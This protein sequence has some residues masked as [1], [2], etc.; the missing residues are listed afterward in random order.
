MPECPASCDAPVPVGQFVAAYLPRPS[1]QSARIASDE[2][3]GERRNN[4]GNGRPS[5]N[6]WVSFGPIHSFETDTRTTTVEKQISSGL[7]ESGS[8]NPKTPRPITLPPSPNPASRTIPTVPITS[9]PTVESLDDIPDARYPLRPSTSY[10]RLSRCAG[11]QVRPVEARG[12]GEDRVLARSWARSL[13]IVDPVGPAGA[14][15]R[16]GWPPPPATEDREGG[17]GLGPTPVKRPGEIPLPPR[18]FA[19]IVRT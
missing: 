6:A 9:N 14:D 15:R 19:A 1:P 7:P 10:P 8:G 18:R 5:A 17:T 13:R 2:T 16:T 4:P 12:P 11:Y 3:R